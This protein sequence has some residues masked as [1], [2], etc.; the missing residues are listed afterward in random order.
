MALVNEVFA[1]GS[2][3][4]GVLEDDYD[5]GDFMD[6]VWGIGDVMPDRLKPNYRPNFHVEM[7]RVVNARYGIW[8]SAATYIFNP[9]YP[10]LPQQ[11]VDHFRFVYERDIRP[12]IRANR[13]QLLFQVQEQNPGAAVPPLPTPEGQGWNPQLERAWDSVVNRQVEYPTIFNGPPDNIDWGA[14][15]QRVD[16]EDRYDQQDAVDHIMGNRVSRIKLI[17]REYRPPEGNGANSDLGLTT[18]V[19]R[20][21]GTASLCGQACL[22]YVTNGMPPQMRKRPSA[23]KTKSEAL[24]KEIGIEGPMGL[25]SF[26]HF[27]DYY[28]EHPD[29]A[30][31]R[32][33]RVIVMR[34]RKE[35]LYK[36][37]P[38]VPIYT[39]IYLLLHKGHFVL[40]QNIQRFVRAT[41]KQR[42]N[43]CEYCYHLINGRKKKTHA[44]EGSCS[45]CRHV[46]VDDAERE[47]HYGEETYDRCP[48]CNFSYHYM[49]CVPYHSCRRWL[50]MV[51]KNV[52][53]VAR[54]DEH[55]CGEK[56]CRSCLVY[57]NPDVHRCYIT[58]LSPK[59][60]ARTLKREGCNI[61]AYDI[62][63]ML[64]PC[65]NDMVRHKIGVIVAMELYTRERLVFRGPECAL[66][67]HRWVAGFRK[68]ATLIAHNASG[69]D[70]WLIFQEF[71][72]N[73]LVYP[74]DIICVGRKIISM[75]CGTVTFI[76]SMRHIAGSLERLAKTFELPL[77]LGSKGFFPYRFYTS[78]NRDYIGEV[79]GVEWFDIPPDKMEKF[80]R[81]YL[82]WVATWLV[83]EAEYA[84]E[85]ECVKYCRQDV[86]M[87]C[88]ALERYRDEGVA[89]NSIDPLSR[90]TIASYALAV[91]RRNHMPA[92]TICVLN[93]T[94]YDFIR[95]GF[96]GGRTDARQLYRSWDENEVAAGRYAKYVDVVSL[97]PTVQ[98]YDLLPVGEPT[99]VTG[100]DGVDCEQWL[101]AL[102]AEG[103]VAFVECSY[104]PPDD[105]YHPVLVRKDEK[106]GRLLASLVPCD[107]AVVTSIELEKAIVMGYGVTMLGQAL[108]FD[109][110]RTLFASYVDLYV[111]IKI[112][113]SGPGGNKGR[114]NLAK[115]LANSLWGKLA[116]RDSDTKKVIYDDPARWF[117]DVAMYNAGALDLDVLEQTDAYLLADRGRPDT[118]RLHLAT[119]NLA[120]AAF[121]TARARLRLY[122]GLELVNEHVLYHDTDSIIYEVV[123][124]LPD[125]DIGNELGMWTDETVLDNGDPDPIVEICCLGPKTYGYRTQSGYEKVLSKGF[126]SCFTLE[127][128]HQLL[129]HG[130]G[131]EIDGDARLHMIRDS[132]GIKSRSDYVKRLVFDLQKVHVISFERTVP[133]GHREAV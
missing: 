92:D 12:H 68:K 115:S 102:H 70:A 122:V 8:L 132:T 6:A 116:Q 84:L 99:H 1:D 121:V 50:C 53:D 59:V 129:E 35:V 75:K 107:N 119:T 7:P 87:L 41:Y 60:D 18:K 38:A 108:V 103:K 15:F 34:D 82:E 57:D 47:A 28:A 55:V 86:E 118:E 56:W 65:E 9:N 124:G 5:R 29:G 52:Y 32:V 10:W 46:F 97:Y 109:T 4:G 26:Q 31:R 19:I 73:A 30:K 104:D 45:S 40:I 110:S 51:C 89:M 37:E 67:F 44:C 76:D 22:A 120:L 94:E 80:N 74:S 16:R 33:Y 90:A 83:D 91:Y 24:A 105:L 114:R 93:R 78:E 112:A 13:V 77:E 130:R 98:R 71:K 117:R 100:L 123:P 11:L 2:Y 79:P 3:H 131:S 48:T 17:V 128:Y 54:Q 126:A 14:V 63:S 72:K 133:Y 64:D 106:T 42:V 43:W 95:R 66:E 62:E 39:R 58:K 27:V 125:I 20:D 69:Y 61:W 23:V 127:D 96:Y 113:E 85:D 111:A 101:A 25:V 21:F 81:W 36:T 49:A 88:V